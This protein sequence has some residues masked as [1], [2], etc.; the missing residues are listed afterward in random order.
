M[1][2]HLIDVLHALLKRRME[3][4]DDDFGVQYIFPGLFQQALFIF[5]NT[6]ILQGISLH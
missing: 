6:V 1:I 2:V 5:Y 3:K 4:V